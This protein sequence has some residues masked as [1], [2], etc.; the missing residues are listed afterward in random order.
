MI[1]W[2]S[3]F[4]EASPSPG[5]SEAEIERFVA[6]I[7]QPLSP[8]EIAEI[9]RS[10]QNPFPKEDPLY[11]VY[12]P[13]DP[14][15]WVM[16]SKPLPESYLAMLRWSNAGWSRTGAREF[17]WFPTSDPVN[18]VRAMTLAYH[19]PE[20]MPG[21]LPFAFDGG[22]TF[23][24]FDIRQNAVAGEYPVVCAHSGNLG[25]EA[26]QCWLVGDSFEAAC[27]GRISIHDLRSDSQER[28]AAQAPERVDVLVVRVPKGGLRQLRSACNHL[29]VTVS[30][31][32]LP[33]ILK[34][35]PYRLS[36]NVPYLPAARLVAE[37]CGDDPCLGVFMV[38]RPDLPV[39]LPPWEWK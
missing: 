11:A 18:G 30:V 4:D 1:D 35:I 21:A 32:E 28:D 13:F 14:S 6:T 17:D 38:D 2:S 27:R 3:I 12:R 39:S 8:G 34:K 5:A 33:A 10:Q 23:Y 36:S 31:A 9:N 15:L 7:G 22:G 25:W 16:P 24:L 29:G 19:V 37:L 20:H 26:D